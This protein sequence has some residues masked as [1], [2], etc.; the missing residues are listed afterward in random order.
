MRYCHVVDHF[1]PLSRS[2]E[3]TLA[4]PK[5]KWLGILLMTIDTVLDQVIATAM[6]R[7]LITRRTRFAKSV[8]RS[9]R[10]RKQPYSMYILVKYQL[11]HLSSGW[12]C[13]EH[14]VYYE[15]IPISLQMIISDLRHWN[16]NSLVSFATVISVQLCILSPPTSSHLVF[17]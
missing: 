5:D 8:L 9:A 1:N 14:R 12:I 13:R 3:V 7:S 11:N 17:L 4:T 15:V 6:A 16:N 10:F 2:Y